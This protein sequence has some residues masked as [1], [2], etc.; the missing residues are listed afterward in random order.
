MKSKNLYMLMRMIMISL[1]GVFAFAKVSVRAHEDHAETHPEATKTVGEDQDRH[2]AREDESFAVQLTPEQ[3]RDIGLQTAVAEKGEMPE[4]LEL[5]GQ[6]NINQD[7]MAHLVPRVEGV[8]EQVYKSLGDTVQAGEVIAVIGS[9]QLADV[10]AAYL[11]AAER[12]AL[13]KEILEREQTLWNEKIIS[14]QE[15][16]AARQAQTEAG[17]EFRSAEQKLLAIGFD[18]AYLEELA[19]QPQRRLTRFE[20]KAPFAGTIIDKHIVHGELVDTTESVFI[21]ADLSTVWVEFQVYPKDLPKVHRQQHVT[22]SGVSEIPPAE[23]TISYIGPVVRTDSRTALARV[24][25][26]NTSG[27]YRPGLF[28]TGRLTESRTAAEVVVPQSAVQ[29][30][31]GKPC[32]FV[33]HEHAFEPVFVQLGRK[34]PDT[35]QILSGLEAGTEYVTDGAFALKSEIITSALSG[36]AGHGH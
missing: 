28:V 23:G 2:E 6:I 33:R 25:L 30:L 21:I 10:K 12:Y 27:V 13:A 15:Y 29:T 1:T 7:R 14:E 22:V 17:I 36:H 4:Y 19:R 24:V 31:E 16:L 35:I 34:G 32:V 8:V 9:R 20:I 26:D 18:S 3:I 11:A 5:P